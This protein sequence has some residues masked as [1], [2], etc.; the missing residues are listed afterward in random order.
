[1]ENNIFRKQ[2]VQEINLVKNHRNNWECI[3]FFFLQRR[4]EVKEM[5]PIVHQLVDNNSLCSSYS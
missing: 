3:I 1:M 4:V 5:F 2:N